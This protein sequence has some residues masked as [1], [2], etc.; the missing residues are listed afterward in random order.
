MKLMAIQ[1]VE[2]MLKKTLMLSVLTGALALPIGLAFAADQDRTQDRAQGQKQDQEQIYG[3]QLMTLQERTEFRA[4]MRA[5]KTAEE[6][7]KLRK[8]H[9]ERMVVRAKERSV[10]LPDEPPVRS[11]SMMGS[12]GV[13]G[14]GGGGMDPGGGRNP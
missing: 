8:E 2:I 9:H 5:T 10:T 14:P 7:E 1:S 4:K 11:G 12:G 6:R 13:M 3:S